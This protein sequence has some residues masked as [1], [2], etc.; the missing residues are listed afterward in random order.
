[1]RWVENQQHVKEMTHVQNIVAGKHE[2]NWLRNRR[3]DSDIE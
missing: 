3:W 2:T 1:M